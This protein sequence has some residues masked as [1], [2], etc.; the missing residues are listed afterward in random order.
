M[1]A[2]WLSYLFPKVNVTMPDGTVKEESQMQGIFAPVVSNFSTDNG[3]VIVFNPANVQATDDS[4]GYSN[5]LRNLKFVQKLFGAVVTEG[6][7]R[8]ASRSDSW[9]VRSSNATAV[10]A[11]N[12]RANLSVSDA[13][14]DWSDGT[15]LVSGSGIKPLDQ[16]FGTPQELLD[17]LDKMAHIDLAAS[18][19]GYGSGKAGWPMKFA[20]AVMYIYLIVVA[21]YFLYITLWQRLRRKQPPYTIISWGDLVDLVVLAWNSKP[22]HNPRTQPVEHHLQEEAARAMEDRGW[23]HGRLYRSG[24]AGDSPRRHGKAQ[25]G[26]RVSLTRSGNRRGTPVSLPTIQDG[27]ERLC[28]G[29]SRVCLPTAREQRYLSAT[30]T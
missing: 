29:R 28:E 10:V 4:E 13:M 8:V 22:S 19:Y 14:Y 24:A 7:A 26:G 2:D 3:P 23:D 6:L 9:L 20:L 15:L 17:R 18:R 5:A 12:I 16:S 30:R 1:T 25:E 11:A 21:T 27:W